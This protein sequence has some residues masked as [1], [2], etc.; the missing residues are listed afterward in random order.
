MA[1]L[2]DDGVYDADFTPYLR[3]I[4]YGFG[5]EDA[6]AAFGT[7]QL[8]ATLGNNDSRFSPKNDTGPYFPDLKRGRRVRL[9]ASMA[10]TFPNTTNLVENPSAETNATGWVAV[11]G[12]TVV[13]DTTKAYYGRASVKVTTANSVSSGTRLQKIDGTRFAVT[14][15]LDYVFAP[16][17]AA[18]AGKALRLSL[19]WYN[20]AAG[21]ISQIDGDFTGINVD[22]WQWPFL[23]GLAP[24][25]AVT[26]F[27]YVYTQS[28]IGVFDFYVEGFFYA[29]S[30][31]RPYVDGDQPGCTWA[32]TAHASQ[33]TRLLSAQQD[34][35]Q[36]TGRI[37]GFSLDRQRLQG[38]MV[39]DCTAGQETYLRKR[40]SCG[41]FT[42]KRANLIAQRLADLM[43][44]GEIIKDG[45]ER[46]KPVSNAES[47]TYVQVGA[48]TPARNASGKSDPA[49]YGAMEGDNLMTQGN[50]AA[51]D[52]WNIDVTARIANSL[53]HTVAC[54]F[55]TDEAGNNGKRLTLQLW[56]DSSGIVATTT[57]TLVT[58]A[59]VYASAAGIFGGG[60][61]V[62]EVRVRATD[63]LQADLIIDYAWDCL[64]LVKT[65][66]R[67]ARTIRGMDYDIE[68]MASFHRSGAAI[69]NEFAKSACGWFYE[70]AA[71][72]LVFEQASSERSATATPKLRLSDG[73]DG[74]PYVLGDYD[75][76]AADIYKKFR[77]GSYGDISPLSLTVANRRLWNLEPANRV[78]GA[79]EEVTYYVDYVAEQGGQIIGRS[80]PLPSTTVVLSAGALAANYPIIRPYGI[81]AELV[82][83][84]G[85]GGATIKELWI[86]GR[87]QYRNTNERSYVEYNPGGSS[88]EADAPLELETPAQ[89]YKEAAMTTYATWVGDKY[90]KGPPKID[91][92]IQGGPIG[93]D[94]DGILG[95]QNTF[96]IIGR[97]EPGTPVWFKHKTGQAALYV[98]GLMY[99]ESRKVSQRAGK[100][101][102]VALVLEEA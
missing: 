59:W 74:V 2:T 51:G 50:V 63:T 76:A 58:N 98:D 81:A 92:A 31:R 69:L 73:L 65:S 24:V 83:K 19:A 23:T 62:R 9:R 35:E 91:A 48:T 71:G 3:G 93:T 16:R 13:R 17:V 1:D 25:G 60:N 52:G 28:A 7:R 64:H 36:F 18:P 101:P 99:I 34:I 38:E 87:F 20:A 100:V 67:I 37:R 29:G 90:V 26:A 82:V 6:L 96:E 97:P 12:A 33:S 49:D 46:V 5:R 66:N 94:E 56:G 45:A 55:T 86:E 102:Q 84:A 15:G 85:G 22:T 53:N 11:T 47:E 77:V 57:V 42:R 78:L 4:D 39:M 54:F 27:L 41:P 10:V 79:N 44:E 68:F 40:I 61:T 21:V 8:K 88:L 70:D 75:E 43:E 72:G 14:A 80:E 89:G 95:W 32:G 30:A